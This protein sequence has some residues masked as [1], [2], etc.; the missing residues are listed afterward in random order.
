MFM[1]E[2]YVRGFISAKNLCCLMVSS[3]LNSLKDYELNSELT[4]KR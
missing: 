1:N 2:L 4:D 3:R